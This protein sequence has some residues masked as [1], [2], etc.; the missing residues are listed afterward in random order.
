MKIIIGVAVFGALAYY[1]YF[2]PV[3]SCM[4]DYPNMTRTSCQLALDKNKK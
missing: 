2:S 1:Y 3:A 4:R